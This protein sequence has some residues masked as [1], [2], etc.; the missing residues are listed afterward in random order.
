[1]TSSGWTD[2]RIR[3]LALSLLLAVAAWPAVAGPEQPHPAATVYV[4]PVAGDV[5]P[6]MAAFLERAFRDTANAKDALFVLEMDTFGGRVDSALRIVDAIV[7]DAPSRTVAFVA[8]KAISAGALIALACHELAMRPHTTI[9]DCA[10]IAY[11]DEGPQMLGE[12]FQS[13]LRA[14]FRAL[15]RRNGYPQRLAEAMVTAEMEVY[16]VITQD[17]QRQFLDTPELEQLAETDQAAIRS[18]RLVVAAGELLTMD[19]V[20]ARELGFARHTAASLDDLLAQLGMSSA[21]VV[22]LAPSWSE[23]LGSFISTIAPILLVIGL[24]ALYTEI[25]SPGFGL[26]GVIG[27]LCLGLVFLNQ[28]LMGLADHTELLL[29]ALG[30]ALLGLEVFVLPGFGIAG[31][32]GFGCLLVGMILAFQDFVIPSPDMPWQ[33]E[34]LVTNSIRV[35]GATIAA[36][37][38]ALFFLRHLLP[39]LGRVVEGPYLDTS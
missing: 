18:K 23:A 9:G 33:E 21:K 27:I 20:E 3:L 5:D 13:P 19:D 16:E 37:L 15:A 30:L 39:R 38:A 35:L 25:K 2:P 17:G 1:M 31:L 26:P 8:G 14:K 11:S 12:K 32:A 34:L 22:H 7:N 10:P 6:G 24:G 36:F 29:I 28:Y 4:L